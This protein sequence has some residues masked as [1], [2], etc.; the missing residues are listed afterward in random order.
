MKMTSVW[1]GNKPNRKQKRAV[2]KLRI[3]WTEL[4]LIDP[5]AISQERSMEQ[6]RL[7]VTALASI[8]FGEETRARSEQPPMRAS[9]PRP[10]A[11][12]VRTTR[13]PPQS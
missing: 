4:G 1:R 6:I 7:E 13:R 11:N 5:S 2:P 8:G 3:P 12:K 9:H 10:R